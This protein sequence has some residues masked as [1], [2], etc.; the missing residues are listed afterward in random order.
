[1]KIN[2]D[3]MLKQENPKLDSKIKT[4]SKKIRR[5]KCKVKSV[6]DKF[7]DLLSDPRKLK[8]A[9]RKIQSKLK[10]RVIAQ[11]IIKNPQD[12]EIAIL[13]EKLK[14]EIVNS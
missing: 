12:Q 4:E 9:T 14:K 11:S 3:P 8:S 2:N 13:K 10:D 7:S 1:M 5:V 6:I